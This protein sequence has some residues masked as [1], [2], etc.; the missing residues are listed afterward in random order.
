MEHCYEAEPASR[1]GKY[2]ATFRSALARDGFATI[3]GVGG[4][5]AATT[6]YDMWK[7]AVSTFGRE[8]ALGHRSIGAD[9]EVGVFS[10][11]TYAEADD[12]AQAVGAFLVAQGL[13]PKDRAG[14]LATNRPEWFITMQ[15]CNR[16]SIYTV[17]LYDTLGADSVE[18]IMN[19]AEIGVVFVQAKAAPSL[20]DV[21]A[22]C[23]NLKA[24]VVYEGVPGKVQPPSGVRLLSYADAVLEGRKNSVDPNPP[25][26]DDLCT[27]MYTSGTTGVP[28]GVLL[29]HRN[30]L[31]ATAGI[32][33]FLEKG[34]SPVKFGPGDS[35]ISYL[36]L[37][38]IFER[39][40]EEFMLSVGGK[41]GYWQGE[42]PKLLDDIGLLKPTLFP[43]VPRIFERIYQGVQQKVAEGGCVKGILFRTAFRS[44]ISAIN[45]GYTSD[46][47]G[48]LWDKIV[49]KSVKERVG[50]R[51]KLIVSGGAALA[52]HLED[53][54]RVT[55][56][57][58]IVQGFGLTETCAASTIQI[59]D[60]GITMHYTVGPPLPS[61]DVRLEAVPEMGYLPSNDPPRGEVCLRGPAVFQGYYKMDKETAECFPDND[62]WFHTGDIGQFQNCALKIVDRKKNIIKL[63]QGEYVALE[64]CEQVL[65]KC[66][67]VGQIW[68]YARSTSNFLICVVVPQDKPLQAAAAEL[69]VKGGG[70]MST[71]ELC[72]IPEL[73]AHVTKELNKVARANGL[74]GFEIPRGVYL[75]PIAFSV[76]DD[77]LTPSFKLKRP[78]LLEHFKSEVDTLY[79]RLE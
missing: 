50:G 68:I 71:P 62:G 11:R 24:I 56:C 73:S 18:Y 9:G 54:L 44:K 40:S 22:K 31:S 65:S 74:K 70:S 15:G 13:G 51:V 55:M 1:D 36:P 57:C 26:P 77:L 34:G 63:A 78:Q 59:P 28:K 7:G 12:E 47:A 67:L 37:A 3:D 48:G 33:V 52:A 25:K 76:D 45:R 39:V 21:A 23:P 79:R 19:H 8:P 75:C 35:L 29:T 61:V 6:L 72:A 10:W 69:G 60:G 27:I 58:P 2:S 17:P 66:P 14:I 16:H 43:G 42:V 53:F 64:K 38:H 41:V 5:P 30:V 4:R 49:F 20:C 46:T 32:R